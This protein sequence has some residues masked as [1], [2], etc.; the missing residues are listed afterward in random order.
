MKK[1]TKRFDVDITGEV[2]IYDP[3][4]EGNP[5]FKFE[6][7]VS[8]GYEELT[9]ISDWNNYLR[10]VLTQYKKFR[11]EM[12]INFIPGWFSYNNAQKK[13]LIR[14][15]I[16][17]SSESIPELDLLIPLNKRNTFKRNVIDSLNNGGNC[18]IC[19]SNDSEKYF[20]IQVDDAGVIVVEVTT[21]LIF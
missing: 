19:K 7:S 13:I 12:I 21:D 20:D 6:D 1:L 16:W 8:S 14:H 3:L 5:R 2:I 4:E 11:N 18:N 15:W 9:S 17:D 10:R